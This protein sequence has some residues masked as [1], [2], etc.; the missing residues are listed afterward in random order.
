[1]ADEVARADDFAVGAVHP[2]RPGVGVPDGD[3]G[4]E[5]DQHLARLV[6]LSRQ[7]GGGGVVAVEIFAADGDADDPFGAVFL[8]RGFEGGVF[9]G[10]VRGVFGLGWVSWEHWKVC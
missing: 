8:H 9:G 4:A 2:G 3:V 5:R 7:H 10:V 1:M 6:D